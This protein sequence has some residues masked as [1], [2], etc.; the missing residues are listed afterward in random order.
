MKNI[1]YELCMNLV[2][3]ETKQEAIKAGI[4]ANRII[5]AKRLIQL[6]EHLARYKVAD[7][8]LDTYPYTAHTTCSDS[9]RAGLPVLTL[10]GETFASRVASSLLN[11]IGLSELITKNSYEYEKKAIELGNDLSKVV[12]L[13]EKI[14]NNKLTK[15]LFN[16][17]L[18]T[19]HIEQAYFEMYKRYN[20]N[21]KPE[22]IEIK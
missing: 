10:Q 17:K 6:E 20:K 11:A 19:S 3:A 12:G 2:K 9:L 22:N 13:K 4:D 5:F 7:L 16:T 18:F 1:L 14:E 15:S 21:E 8:F